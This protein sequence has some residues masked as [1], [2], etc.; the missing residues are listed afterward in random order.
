MFRGRPE[1]G[2]KRIPKTRRSVSKRAIEEFELGCEW[3]KRE[4]ERERDIYI[5]IYRKRERE[6]KRE[7]ERE[8]ER[9]KERES[10]ED[11]RIVIPELFLLK[12]L[13]MFARSTIHELE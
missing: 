2:G 6:R 9:E 11:Y 13:C 8:R 12:H 4:R 3:R 1:I 10:S 7:K 5:Y